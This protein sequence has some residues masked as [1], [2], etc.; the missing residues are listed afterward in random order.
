[1]ILFT[2]VKFATNSSPVTQRQKSIAYIGL[3]LDMLLEIYALVSI[4]I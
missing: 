2:I 4:C 3:L 1:M